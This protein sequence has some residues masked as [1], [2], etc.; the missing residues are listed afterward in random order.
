MDHIIKQEIKNGDPFHQSSKSQISNLTAKSVLSNFL[1]HCLIWIQTILKYPLH[2]DKKGVHNHLRVFMKHQLSIYHHL[3]IVVGWSLWNIF[4]H[5]DLI[6]LLHHSHIKTF[7]HQSS[8][9]HKLQHTTHFYT[10]FINNF[11]LVLIQNLL[12]WYHNI[13]VVVV[14][15]NNGSAN[16]NNCLVFS[17]CLECHLLRWFTLF[18]MLSVLFLLR[19]CWEKGNIARSFNRINFC[20]FAIY[21]LFHK[22]K[23]CI[24]F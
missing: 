21:C 18:I 11:H 5:R 23:P 1:Q 24:N 22:K 19:N 8:T 20:E 16:Q 12:C 3:V 9:I 15:K 2:F 6:M 4:S 14:L 13:S 10:L 17:F 7:L